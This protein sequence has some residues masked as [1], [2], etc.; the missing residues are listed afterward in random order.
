MGFYLYVRPRRKMEAVAMECLGKNS[1]FIRIG[2]RPLWISRFSDTDSQMDNRDALSKPVRVT[3][4]RGTFTIEGL[5]SDAIA[6]FND[7]QPGFH[8]KRHRI[9]HISGSAGK[10]ATN[11]QGF[12][13]APP[14][15][16]ISEPNDLREYRLVSWQDGD[17]GPLV[18][19]V[20]AI[21]SLS[22]CD[23]MQ[24]QVDEILAW[25][26]AEEWYLD[27]DIPWRLGVLLYGRPGCGKTSVVRA[28]AEMLDYP[29]YSFDLATLYNDELRREWSHML[30]ETP[31]VALFED[32]DAI[33]DGRDPLFSVTFDCVLNCLDGVD[34][35]NGLL[36]FIT[37]NVGDRIDPAIAD[38]SGETVIC[39]RPGRIDR[40]VQLGP[41][42]EE[43]R[44][45]L[46]GRILAGFEDEQRQ[47]V[48]TGDGDTGAQFQDRCVRAVRSL[49]TVPLA[50][51]RSV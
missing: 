12:Y 33:F 26:K 23:D 44:W 6:V 24:S 32:F 10:Q 8:N 45:K 41:L 34:R 49:A 38:L 16:P 21:D 14:Q 51:E 46:A 18:P 4:I 47:L 48:E 39:S 50:I 1:Q 31:C 22:L 37:T 5:V 36:V 2:W 40:C 25:S 29:V 9:R 28:V 19:K 30:S 3:F 42:S 13:G 17:I 7:R 11:Q 35:V 15:S 43:G 20:K 27:R